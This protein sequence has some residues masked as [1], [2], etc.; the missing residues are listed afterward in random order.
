MRLSI[1]TVNYNNF[2]GLKK[3]VESVVAQTCKDYEWIVIDGGSTD[4]SKGLLDEYSGDITYWVSEKDRGVYHAMNKG[5][6][7]AKGEYCLFLNSG[8][9]LHSKE[10]VKVVLPELHTDDIISGDEWW[11]DENY[12]FKKVNTNP[13]A[14]TPYRL[15]AGILWHQCT[16]IRRSLLIEHPYDES[17]KISSDWEEMFYELVVRKGTYRHIPVIVSD[18]TVGGISEDGKLIAKE[19]A[20]VL[21]RYLTKKEQ[22]I[23]AL[24]YLSQC[25]DSFHNKQIA[26]LAFSSF[27]N[28]W[29]NN[30]EYNELFYKYKNHIFRGSSKYS[31]FIGLC[32]MRQMTLAK[33]IYK[34]LKSRK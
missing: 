2:Q 32:F 25:N 5:M 15:L 31:L 9:R 30:K 20:E 19:R 1:I 3:T 16:F 26:E 10:T 14:L 6:L 17:L 23:I 13:E 11:V 18:F 12:S 22:H 24:D 27:V 21:D 34:F 33:K 7:A 4:G 8:D 28:G 29:Y